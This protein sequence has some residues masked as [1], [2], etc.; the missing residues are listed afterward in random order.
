M[1]IEKNPIGFVG[2]KVRNSLESTFFVSQNVVWSNHN[3]I[4]GETFERIFEA[5]WV[6]ATAEELGETVVL[7]EKD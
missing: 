3:I 7:D 6:I 1:M 5:K 2:E 4:A